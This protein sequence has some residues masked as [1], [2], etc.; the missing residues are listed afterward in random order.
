MNQLYILLITETLISE[1]HDIKLTFEDQVWLSK[2]YLL[3]FLK[4][5]N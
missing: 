5:H 1:N 4:I 2:S 3:K